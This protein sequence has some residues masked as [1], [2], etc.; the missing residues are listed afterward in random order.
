MQYDPILGVALENPGPLHIRRASRKLHQHLLLMSLRPLARRVTA[1]T[2]AMVM[3]GGLAV[4]L[5]TVV[6]GAPS[7]GAATVDDLQK[8]ANQLEADINDNAV[9]LDALNE[10]I[11]GAQLKLNAANQ[12]IADAQ[13]RIAAAQAE[14]NRLLGLVR[15]RAAA[16]YRNAA[17]GGSDVLFTGDIT[18]INARQKYADASSAQDNLLLAQLAS[19]QSDLQIVKKDAQTA[20]AAAATEKAGLDTAKADFVA[21][22]NQ[23]QSL[24]GQVQGQIATLVAQAAAARRAAEAPAAFDPSKVPPASGRAGIVVS[25]VQQQLGKPYEYAGTGPSSFDCSGLTMMAWAAAGLSIPHNSEAQ[26]AEFPEVPMN[27][28]QPGDIVW[29]PGHVGIYVGGGAVI[30]APHTGDVVGY[31]GVGYFQRAVRPG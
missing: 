4:A 19:S 18:G 27:A 5:T 28:L 9:K 12:S 24:L 22:Q 17:K 25:Y 8:Q 11:N 30:H 1:T 10:Q 7:A 20:Q 3:A 2:L 6:A 23:R 29:A 16:V 31:I 26:L 15:Q 14:T 21:A 13:A